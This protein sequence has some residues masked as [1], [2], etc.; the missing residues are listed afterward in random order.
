MERNFVVVVTGYIKH[1]VLGEIM[2]AFGRFAE[3]DELNSGLGP[4]VIPYD[5]EGDER[6]V[7][8]SLPLPKGVSL[9]DLLAAIADVETNACRVD[10]KTAEYPHL[11]STPFVIEVG[12]H[13]FHYVGGVLGY[14]RDSTSPHDFRYGI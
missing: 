5:F 4:N 10:E 6:F 9:D 2:E 1:G 3:T 12:G 8:S 14:D 7:V 11:H 13:R